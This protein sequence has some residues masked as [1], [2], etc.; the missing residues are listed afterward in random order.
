[1]AQ[2]NAAIVIWCDEIDA[3]P[4]QPLFASAL[5]L[6][7]GYQ[8]DA[9]GAAVLGAKVKRDSHRLHRVYC[10]SPHS[11]KFPNTANGVAAS[12]PPSTGITTPEI[13]L[14]SSLAK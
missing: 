10:S 12:R 1:M 3:D 7:V 4:Q 11:P 6:G 2:R 5:V 13:H 8:S 14:D 9:N